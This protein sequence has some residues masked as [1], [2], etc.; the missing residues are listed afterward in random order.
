MVMEHLSYYE[1]Q[2]VEAEVEEEETET[3]LSS[4]LDHL[5]HGSTCPY[6]WS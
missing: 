3:D 5:L 2:V 1:L 6:L 4:W